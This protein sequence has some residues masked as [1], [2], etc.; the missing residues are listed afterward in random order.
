MLCRAA[1][2]RN[3]LGSG[4]K[5]WLIRC[6]CCHGDETVSASVLVAAEFVSHGSGGGREHRLINSIGNLGRLCR[7]TI[8]GKVETLR[9][10]LQAG[11]TTC[12]FP[13][14]RRDDHLS[15]GL[16]RREVRERNLLNALCRR[17]ESTS[18]VISSHRHS[19]RAAN[20]F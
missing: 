18:H 14:P 3:K 20:Q 12:A 4:P 13:W 17:P 2:V 9:G 6:L 15:A 10:R 7:P 1:S 16:G 5:R 8:L 11:F 19:F